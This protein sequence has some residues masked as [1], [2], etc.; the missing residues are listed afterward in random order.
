MLSLLVLIGKGA[1]AVNAIVRADKVALPIIKKYL[2][3]YPALAAALL[4]VIVDVAAR[5]GLHVT[6]TELVYVASIAAA[7]TAVPVHAAYRAQVK[8]ASKRA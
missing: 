4:N 5:F 1:N 8:A 2:K 6:P 3:Q 7:V